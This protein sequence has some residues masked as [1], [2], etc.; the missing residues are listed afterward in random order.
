VTN[1]FIYS[2]F[3]FI[4]C[5]TSIFTLRGYVIT[6]HTSFNDMHVDAHPFFTLYRL[7][8]NFEKTVLTKNPLSNPC[9][10]YTGSFDK[11]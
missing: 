10:S 9:M 6:Y 4:H 7:M 2:I 11:Q 1:I 5:V 3:S 8:L